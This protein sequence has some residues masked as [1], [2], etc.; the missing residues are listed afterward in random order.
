MDAQ[1]GSGLQR[2]VAA[3]AR[4]SRRGRSSFG[5]WRRCSSKADSLDDDEIEGIWSAGRERER[6]RLHEG[7][8]Q[9]C[10]GLAPS[11]CVSGIEL[12][13]AETCVVRCC[14]SLVAVAL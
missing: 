14:L 4:G 7:I 9:L 3:V 2:L 11:A 5:A 8:P 10:D 12:A 1:F 13:E 6:A